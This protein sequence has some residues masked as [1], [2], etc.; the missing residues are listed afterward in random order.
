[1]SS[2]SWLDYS[3]RDRR[4]MLEVVDL[5]KERDT[6]DELGLSSVRDSFADQLFPGTSTI[7]TRARYFLLVAWIY[8]DL[9]ERK[10]GSAAITARGRKAETELIEAIERSEDKDGNIG[11]YAR[12][13]L[14]RLPSSVYWQGLKVWGIR[15]FPGSLAQYYRS[16]DHHHTLRRRHNR[17]S[18]ERD[19]EH[20]DLAASNWHGGLV[21]PPKNFPEFCSLRLSRSEAEYLRERIRLSHSSSNSLLAELAANPRHGVDVDFVWEHHDRSSFTPENRELVNHAQDFS[22]V[23]HGAALLYNLILAEQR[24]WKEKIE[25]YEELLDIWAETVER[26]MNIIA[27]GKRN[28]FWERAYQ[29]NPGIRDGAQDFINTWWDMTLRHPPSK[30]NALPAARMLIENRELRL[31]KNLARINNPRARE[32]WSGEA[33][34]AQLDFRWRSSRR[35]LKDIFD[36]LEAA[37]A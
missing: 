33:G 17:R 32:L 22:E 18:E 2:F 10:V 14:K 5:F 20:D 7:M 9:E 16:L 4:K 11:K 6:R 15:T 29:G 28:V 19:S 30:L 37:H 34:S 35:I 27:N 8:R 23:M 25:E 21:A 36:G 24:E 13:A 1:M 31:K 3:E 12:T 26:R